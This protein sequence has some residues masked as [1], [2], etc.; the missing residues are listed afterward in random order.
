MNAVEAAKIEAQAQ[1]SC[2]KNT[3]KELPK[4]CTSV[5]FIILSNING[6]MIFVE[7]FL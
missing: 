6:K 2:Y 5:T 1:P 4:M 7:I 3:I